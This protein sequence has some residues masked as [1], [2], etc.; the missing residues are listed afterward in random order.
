MTNF[1]K[2]SARFKTIRVKAT[3]CPL[4][5]TFARRVGSVA[6]CCSYWLTALYHIVPWT[7]SQV[8]SAGKGYLGVAK[9]VGIMISFKRC[10]D[11]SHE[12]FVG[13]VV[14]STSQHSVSWHT[15]PHYSIQQPTAQECCNGCHPFIVRKF[16]LGGCARLAHLPKP[17]RVFHYFSQFE[18]QNESHQEC[19]SERKCC[20]SA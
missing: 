5:T 6:C 19:T 2:P 7:S 4:C 12:G 9:L 18:N 15:K 13:S 17:Q 11:Y 20:S 10:P 1:F 3:T 8:R 16:E 14:D